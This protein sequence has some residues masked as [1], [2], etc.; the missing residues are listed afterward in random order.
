MSRSKTVKTTSPKALAGN[1]QNQLAYDHKHDDVARRGSN[2]LVVAPEFLLHTRHISHPS[3]PDECH[4]E[5][6]RRSGKR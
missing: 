4:T 2:R 6:I 5:W 3:K 1:T